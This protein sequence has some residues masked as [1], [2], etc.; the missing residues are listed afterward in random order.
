MSALGWFRLDSAERS[1]DPFPWRLRIGLLNGQTTRE[2][3][4]PPQTRTGPGVDCCA[5]NVVG[6]FGGRVAYAIEADGGDQMRVVSV[7]DGTDDT[8]AVESRS[9][10]SLALDPS[11][12]NVYYVPLEADPG[13]AASAWRVPSDG[14]SAPEEVIH[15]S[16]ADASEVTLVAQVQRWLRLLV[17]ADG[18]YVAL[19]ECTTACALQ[20]ADTQT[21]SVDDLPPLTFDEGTGVVGFT[22]RLLLFA[23]FCPDETCQAFSLDVVT[24]TRSALPATMPGSAATVEAAE[25]GSVYLYESQPEGAGVINVTAL[26][27]S[28]GETRVVYQSAPFEPRERTERLTPTHDYGHGIEL[29]P[30]WFLVWLGANAAPARVLEPPI[31]VHLTDGTTIELPALGG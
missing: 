29:P 2:M 17:S 4:F 14:S 15:A 28:T 21:G 3:S 23:P 31:A 6:P 22:D 20:V 10:E 13:T 26:D 5:P 19:L 7:A 18:R 8:I 27:P 16:S 1:D 24:N 11:G 9:V 25:F 12:S 30:V